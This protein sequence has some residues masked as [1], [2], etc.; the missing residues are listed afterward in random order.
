MNDVQTTVVSK[1]I[2]DKE[3][4]VARQ[5]VTPGQHPVD[6]TV[7]FHGTMNVGD[8]YERSPTTSIPWLEV[9]T[10]YREVF[11]RAIDD[12]VAKIDAGGSVDRSDLT[13]MGTAGVL[14]TDV[15][16]DCIRTALQNGASAVG[17]VQDRVKEVEAGVEALKKDLVNKAPKQ[18]V[19]GKV[20]LDVVAD[21][22][23]V[24][25]GMTAAEVADAVNPQRQPQVA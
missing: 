22:V 18:K 6:F 1:I 4:K 19:P 9:T 20:S 21:V 5:A 13:S 7:R 17:T 15:L 11:R 3:S 2:G 12:L 23:G 8:D 24:P 10:L 14:T 16:V 25:Q